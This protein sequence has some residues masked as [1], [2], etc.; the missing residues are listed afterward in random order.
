MHRDFKTE[1][2]LLTV[3]GVIKIADFGLSRKFTEPTASLEKP[4]YS[5]NVVTQ[6]YN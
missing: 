3:D 4:K 2:I 5:P 6:W 1:N